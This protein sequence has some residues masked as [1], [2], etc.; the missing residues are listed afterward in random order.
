MKGIA[1][2]LAFAILLGIVITAVAIVLNVS[3]PTIELATTDIDVKISEDILHKID[4]AINDIVR[5]GTNSTRIVTFMPTKPI[6]TIPEED[7]VQFKASLGIIDYFSRIFKD[8]LVYIA[9]NDVNCREEDMNMDGVADLV[10]EN[11]FIKAGFQK[12]NKT[13]PLSSINTTSNIVQI[14]EKTGSTLISP[15]NS[16]III[17]DNQTT[18]RGVGYSELLKP[19]KDLPVCTA[20][21]FVNSTSVSYDVFYR[22]YAGADFLAVEVR[23][24]R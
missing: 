11:T 19:G 2:L 16:S 9:G 17:D 21:F 7:A 5:E 20:H 23:N 4:N 18:A 8:N 24:I 15:V 22:L 12:I 6:E 3:N 10:L 13:S 1:N 14:M